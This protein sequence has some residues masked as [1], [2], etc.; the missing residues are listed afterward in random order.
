MPTRIS[1]RP[2][3]SS[4]ALAVCP[5]G[6][7]SHRHSHDCSQQADRTPRPSS[8]THDALRPS[9][10]LIVADRPLGHRSSRSQPGLF[11]I[12]EMVFSRPNFEDRSIVFELHKADT[13]GLTSGFP[14]LGNGRSILGRYIDRRGR[15]GRDDHV[16]RQFIPIPPPSADDAAVGTIVMGFHPGK[17]AYDL[18]FDAD[19]SVCRRGRVVLN[20]RQVGEVP[21]HDVA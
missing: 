16:H 3:R 20:A 21:L 17:V 2:G 15:V 9:V 7:E 1:A 18:R 13:S 5:D 10:C 6:H 11:L 8:L 12:H 4:P 14:A 19:A